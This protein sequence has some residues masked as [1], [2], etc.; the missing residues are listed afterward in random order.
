[1]QNFWNYFAFAIACNY[2]GWA[3]LWN[4]KQHAAVYSE[5]CTRQKSS[6]K[7]NGWQNMHR[8]GLLSADSCV[9]LILR[10]FRCLLDIL[11]SFAKSGFVI[12][13]CTFQLLSG[14]VICKLFSALRTAQVFLARSISYIWPCLVAS[15]VNITTGID[16]IN[17]LLKEKQW[18][19]HEE[20]KWS[21]L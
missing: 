18:R 2:V 20:N 16:Q 21:Q 12:I 11:L 5:A 19:L 10:A 7:A 3:D 4:R 14:L 9:H 8:E 1:M 17:L 15:Y 13:S 6:D